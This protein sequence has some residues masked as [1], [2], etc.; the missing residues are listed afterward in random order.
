[1]G[2]DWEWK[3]TVQG[4]MGATTAPSGS[5][6]EF[7]FGWYAFNW[8]LKLTICLFGSAL[9][10][11]F[12]SK[13]YVFVNHP[14]VAM[15]FLFL[16]AATL[17]KLTVMFEHFRSTMWLFT[18]V[19]TYTFGA[20]I[21]SDLFMVFPCFEGAGGLKMMLHDPS[22]SCYGYS[23]LMVLASLAICAY[24]AVA[25]YVLGFAFWGRKAIIQQPAN[26]DKRELEATFK[27]FGF[28]FYGTHANV[29]RTATH[30]IIVTV[31]PISSRGT[32]AVTE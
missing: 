6:M 8:I 21:I 11:D 31:S 13:I 29:S 12:Q 22:T 23:T 19:F 28:L 1:M 15:A 9:S 20:S 7:D 32:V 16:M 25:M 26:H 17:S 18:T 30:T 2:V 10:F 3:S 24:T 27:E 5:I 4:L 14:M